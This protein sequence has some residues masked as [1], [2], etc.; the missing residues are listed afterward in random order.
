MH[1]KGKEKEMVREKMVRGK[2]RGGRNPLKIGTI[3][4]QMFSEEESK[5]QKFISFILIH[6]VFSLGG[7]P[8][9]EREGGNE[10]VK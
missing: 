7:K 10:K 4:I 8:E 6:L 9:R 3:S 5:M 1:E 2:L